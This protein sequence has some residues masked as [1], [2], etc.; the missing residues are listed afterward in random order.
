MP[1]PDSGG[2]LSAKR[3]QGVQRSR[4]DLYGEAGTPVVPTANSSRRDSP[5]TKVWIDGLPR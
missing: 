4:T 3:R 2:S 5:W 1:A